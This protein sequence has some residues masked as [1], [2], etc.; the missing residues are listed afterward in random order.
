M[1]FKGILAD[2]TIRNVSSGKV[3]VNDILAAPEVT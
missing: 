2:R 3:L 1:L